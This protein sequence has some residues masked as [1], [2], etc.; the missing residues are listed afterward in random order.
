MQSTDT[1]YSRWKDHFD[2]A[3]SRV[4]NALVTITVHPQ[5][6]GRAHNLLMFERLL[7][8]M[9]SFEDVWFT[10]LSTVYEHWSEA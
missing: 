9:T 7:D 10:N 4:P 3:Y 1:I 6:I 5:S 8:Y 2:F